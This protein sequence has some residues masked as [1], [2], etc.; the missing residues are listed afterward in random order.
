VLKK[1]RK[2]LLISGAGHFYENVYPEGARNSEANLVRILRTAYPG[3]LFIAMIR[4]DEEIARHKIPKR[5]LIYTRTHSLGELPV[6]QFNPG[7]K[8]KN[9]I[10]AILFM[11]EITKTYAPSFEDDD[12]YYQEY[13]RRR[14]ITSTNP[15]ETETAAIV[16][17]HDVDA[18]KRAIKKLLFDIAAVALSDFDK[19]RQGNGE[20]QYN[21]FVI[22]DGFNDRT[23]NYFFEV[24]KI[25]GDPNG[26][27][28]FGR[29]VNGWPE[30]KPIIEI[31][32]GIDKDDSF[33]IHKV[34][35]F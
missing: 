6:S 19:R 34:T 33:A 35:V 24:Q 18:E 20:A 4:T 8:L 2:A 27:K 21:A 28:L 9:E 22:P 15:F 10:D 11:G 3:S 1:G 14:T 25:P 30:K 12:P 7:A 26:L 17:S 13:L 31:Q 32:V 29:L 16:K 23:K 5:S